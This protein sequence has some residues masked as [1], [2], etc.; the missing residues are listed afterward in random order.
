MNNDS[1]N[2]SN[3]FSKITAQLTN[4]TPL[5]LLSRDHELL[6]IENSNSILKAPVTVY[7]LGIPDDFSFGGT[8]R[9]TTLYPHEYRSKKNKHCHELL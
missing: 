2:I 3:L 1:T 8:F 9:E 4:N 7:S 5:T 6:I